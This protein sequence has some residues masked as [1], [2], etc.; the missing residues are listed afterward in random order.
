MNYESVKY[1]EKYNPTEFK[2]PVRR[3]KQISEQPK[4]HTNQI[5]T[6]WTSTRNIKAFTVASN[7][8]I[9]PAFI[10]AIPSKGLIDKPL[11]LNCPLPISHDHKL[12]QLRCY[13]TKLDLMHAMIKPDQND[14]DWQVNNIHEWRKNKDQIFLKVCWIGGDK[15]WLLL[16]DM[17]LHDP[18]VVIRYALRAKLNNEPGWEWTNYYMSSDLTLNNMVHAYKASWF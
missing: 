7:M 13:H 8:L 2:D 14:Y 10:Q 1:K 11:I 15:Q 18:Y 3:S 6:T 5:G 17:R 16:D 9:V 4:S 12:E